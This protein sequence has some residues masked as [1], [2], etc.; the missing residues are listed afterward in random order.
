MKW[1]QNKNAPVFGYRVATEEVEETS[2]EFHAERKTRGEREKEE[3][4][5]RQEND[6]DKRERKKRG[7]RKE[8]KKVVCVEM[9]AEEEVVVC[10][11]CDNCVHTRNTPHIEREMVVYDKRDTQNTL[12][13]PPLL[14]VV[15]VV[16]GKKKKKKKK[17]GR[18]EHKKDKFLFERREGKKMLACSSLSLSLSPLPPLLCSPLYSPSCSA[19]A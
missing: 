4:N 16:V 19:C 6:R 3:K 9:Q 2:R 7:E 8:K 18:V 5:K 13:A 11:C 12:V 17:G 1:K 15:V 14:F 10:V